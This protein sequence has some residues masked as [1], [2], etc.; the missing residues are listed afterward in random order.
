MGRNNGKPVHGLHYLRKLAAGH[1]QCAA[2]PPRE[3]RTRQRLRN[4]A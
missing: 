3:E 2:K 4:L 1:A